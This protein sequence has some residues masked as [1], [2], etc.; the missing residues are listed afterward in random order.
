MAFQLKTKKTIIISTLVI[1]GLAAVFGYTLYQSKL[2]ETLLSPANIA[3]NYLSPTPSVANPPLAETPTPTPTPSVANPPLAETPTPTPTPRPAGP[4]ADLPVLMYH[5]IQEYDVAKASGYQGLTV[6][7]ENF[8]KQLTYLNDRGYNSITP[9][10]L[11]AFFD[12]GTSLPKKPIMLTFD[13][14]YDDF[15]TYA[16]PLLSQFNIKASMYLPT[17]LLENPGYLK[18]STISSLNNG[19]IYFGNH[20]WS[21]K[22]MGANLEVDKKEVTTAETQ[23]KDHGLNASKVFVYPYGTVGAGIVNYLR[24]SGYTLA[25]TTVNGRLQC[26]GARLTLPR[27][28]IGNSSLSIY[29]L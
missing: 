17:G 15:A 1:L 2:S 9:A 10:Q 20:T 27:I 16:A 26:K 18:W 14:G 19:N 3:N 28:R 24:D 4:C 12:S 13:D 29:G 11:I 8:K 25:F 22:S 23:L 5:H 6:T 7:P 21:H